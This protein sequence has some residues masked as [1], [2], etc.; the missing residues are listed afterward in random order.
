[1]AKVRDQVKERTIALASNKAHF[2]EAGSGYPTIFLHGAAFTSA[3]EDWFP[4]IKHGLGAV[5]HV[6]A[7]DQLGWGS[8]D[9]PVYR[10]E[11]GFLVDHVRE[12]QDALGYEKTNIV[13]H[14]LGGWVAGTLAYE[15][16]E[17]VNKLVFV[18]NAGLNI[19]PPPNLADFKPSS[20][21]DLES[22]DVPSDPD[23][24]AELIEARER[25]IATPGAV[26]A[27]LKLGEMFRD[28][29]MRRRYFLHRKLKHIKA[30]T[31]M[32]FGEQDLIFPSPEGRDLMNA[33]IKGSRKVVLADT[34]HQ[35]PTQRPAELTQL[36][37]EFLR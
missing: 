16:P 32:V 24:R 21:A 4:C 25:I 1:M 23:L 18:A 37:K 35:V 8:A 13:G 33:E 30:Q 11:F 9:R 20:R 34:G 7:L 12:L 36:L 10:Y 6:H 15:S 31:L 26:D 14:S 22:F 19:A 29:D 27:Y 28:M 2:Y 3:G 5:T 17:R